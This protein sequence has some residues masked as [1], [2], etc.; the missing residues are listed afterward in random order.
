MW[1][2]EGARI[3][4][5]T[6]TSCRHP[7][8]LLRSFGRL[9]GFFICQNRVIGHTYRFAQAHQGSDRG[10]ASS[11]LYMP[12]E[13]RTNATLFGELFL[14]PV[15]CFTGGSDAF[16]KGFVVHLDHLRDIVS[17]LG[18]GTMVSL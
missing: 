1:Y 2:S 18:Q 3:V 12:A 17:R 4:D 13:G 16:A 7:P 14:R 5:G 10:D 8:C 11:A 15:F 6:D 9:R